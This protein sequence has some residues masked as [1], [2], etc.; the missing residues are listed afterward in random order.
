MKIFIE[1]SKN[2][3]TNINNICK[4]K[5]KYLQRSAKYGVQKRKICQNSRGKNQ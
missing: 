1:Y 2:I 3:L 4:I 5:S